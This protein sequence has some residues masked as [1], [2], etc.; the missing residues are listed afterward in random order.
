MTPLLR[1]GLLTPQL[2]SKCLGADMRPGMM[3]TPE[4]HKPTGIKGMSVQARW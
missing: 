2:C 1:V 4:T 3:R